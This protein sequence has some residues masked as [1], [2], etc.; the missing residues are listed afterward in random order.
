M[1]RLRCGRPGCAHRI[2]AERLPAAAGPYVQRTARL[3]SLQHRI[4]LALGGKAGARLAKRIGTPMSG[5]TLLR[6]VRRGAATT[7]AAAPRVLGVDDWAWKRGQ[8]YGT[9][10]VDLERQK[11]RSS[12]RRRLAGT[13]GRGTLEKEKPPNLGLIQ[14]GG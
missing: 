9:V 2:F 6:L 3:G 1:R 13:P 11:G 7:P 10:L 5:A 12:R 14:R 4:G 8:R